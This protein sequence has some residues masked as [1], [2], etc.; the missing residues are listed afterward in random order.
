MS[1]A[2]GG[3]AGAARRAVRGTL[4]RMGLELRRIPRPGY[5]ARH[6]AE[7]DA[8]LAALA[9]D[10]R[11][12]SPAMRARCAEYAREVLGDP[13]YAPWLRVCAAMRGD[14]VPGWIPDNYYGRYVVPRRKGAYGTVSNCRAL[15]RLLLDTPA[16][17]DAGYLVNGR[18]FDADRRPLPDGRAAAALFGAADRL[19]FKSD[20]TERGR[21]IRFLDRAGF[22]PGGLRGFGNGVFQTVVDQHPDLAA[23]A[24]G[25]VATLRL[26]TAIAPDG[27][28][29][30]RAAYLRI[31]RAGDSH[32]MSARNVRVVADRATGVL[33]ATGHLPD[34]RACAAHPDTGRPFAGFAVP[35]F[36]EARALVLGLHARLP[37]AECIGWDIAVDATGTPRLLEWNGAHNDIKFSEATHGPCFADLGWERLWRQER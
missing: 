1:R 4:A 20:D 33:D 15:S 17:P 10:G 35:A 21:G 29:E 7:A 11:P 24:P 31:G 34:W 37:F 25:S 30:L 19:I 18:L 8:A 3:L 5:D 13:V 12:L 6:K 26:T 22:D 14:F 2:A 27:A 16:I 28:A 23:F 9:Q 32:V 36:A